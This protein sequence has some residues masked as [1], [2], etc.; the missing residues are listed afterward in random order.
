MSGFE[1]SLCSQGTKTIINNII[2]MKAARDARDAVAVRDM[3]KKLLSDP[4][5]ASIKKTPVQPKEAGKDLS[6]LLQKA[7]VFRTV[8][9][10][11]IGGFMMSRGMD[12]DAE[13]AA[14]NEK[15]LVEK[16]PTFMMAGN[17]TPESCMRKIT[18]DYCGDHTKLCD[19]VR[20]SIT[21]TTEEQIA[22]V[23]GALLGGIN[24]E[25]T[26]VTVERAKNRFDVPL[27]TGIRDVLVNVLVEVEGHGA[28]VCEIQIHLAGIR[29]L[30][31]YCHKY[32]EIFHD[33]FV[34]TAESYEKRLDMFEKVGDVGG[35]EG[36]V[37][38]G[39]RRLL[40]GEDVK[41]LRA[42]RELAGRDVL[43]DPKLEGHAAD[44]IVELTG[45][46]ETKKAAKALSSKGVGQYRN[47]EYDAAL[48]SYGKALE[49][50]IKLEGE[51][52][53][54]VIT[55][56]Q[57]IALVYEGKG[58]LERALEEYYV[59]LKL[60]KASSH[61]KHGEEGKWTAIIIGNM[62]SVHKEMKNY[63]NALELYKRS[64][65]MM[66]KAGAEKATILTAVGQIASTY[67]RAGRYSEAVEWN[68]RGLA[69]QEAELGKNH[70]ATLDS[71]N[72]L[73]LACEEEG[74]LDRAVALHERCLAGREE[75]GDEDEARLTAENLGDT[76]KAGGSRFAA[77]LAALKQKYPDA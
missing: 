7:P 3:P 39:L 46:E 76:L 77:K 51:G 29:A 59:A 74:D 13:V 16:F 6:E 14:L 15:G 71:V 30:K 58:E 57:N 26:T 72:N 49:I 75:G 60:S 62:G 54:N 56:R 50:R 40:Q 47:K 17:K 64:V 24:G 2:G 8:L 66:E 36:G 4:K 35:G 52:G 55:T 53:K 70:P 10:A 61:P 19:A 5:L 45:E 12:P 20:G 27:F 33:I 68:E 38:G 63:D 44:R 42:L 11:A 1:D 28:H 21:L 65:E 9:S 31:G 34:G 69:G 18:D 43:G 41:K 37:E 23:L 67:S 25:G 48:V 73:A 22:A 32:Y